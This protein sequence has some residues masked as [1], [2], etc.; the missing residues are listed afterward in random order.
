MDSSEERSETW[1]IVR[2]VG[3]LLLT[4]VTL[5][6]ILLGRRSFSELNE[7]FGLVIRWLAQAPLT[8]AMALVL[9]SVFVLQIFIIDTSLYVASPVSLLSAWWTILTSGFIHANIEHLLWNLFALIVFGRV[10]EANYGKARW[11]LIFTLSIITGSLLHIGIGFVT[12]DPTGVLGA[13]GGIFGLIAAAM[14]VNPLRITFAQIIPLP[15]AAAA[16]FFILTTTLNLIGGVT[17]GVSHGA[18][19]GGLVCGALIGTVNAREHRTLG[20]ISVV[21]FVVLILVFGLV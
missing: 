8:L 21:L 11:L 5:F 18:H 12:A 15:I 14:I 16:S 20:W 6:L 17:D 19:L 4:P 13:S 1:L 2:L 3:S 7:P 9:T 10:V